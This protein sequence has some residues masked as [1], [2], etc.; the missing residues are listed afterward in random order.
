MHL[1]NSS[2]P[3]HDPSSHYKMMEP[4]HDMLYYPNS[5]TAEMTNQT[6]EGFL[7]SI[8]NDD[9][10]LDMAMNE[11][12]YTMRPL[13][14]N[15]A[16]ANVASNISQGPPLSHPL[17]CGLGSSTGVSVNED[18]MEA[19][20][21]SAVSSM[22]SERIPPMT[23]PPMSDNEWA[24]ADQHAHASHDSSPYSL[25]Y[26]IGKLRGYEYYGKDGSHRVAAPVA[27]KKHQMFGKRFQQEQG[28]VSHPYALSSHP[29]SGLLP[30][31]S[32]SG[33]HQ[34]AGAA[35]LD[36]MEMKYSCSVDFARHHND[37]RV[38]GAGGPGDVIHSN[39][40]YSLPPTH[41]ENSTM[42]QGSRSPRGPPK[43]KSKMMKKFK[44]EEHL[45]RDEK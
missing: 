15:T 23:D 22:G 28:G 27:Q 39:H 7:S 36:P 8:L 18:R 30:Y 1:T 9:D 44:S 41:S 11:G 33:L 29:P 10:L 17:N 4:S 38:G 19:S 14:N 12:L 25:D 40:T 32:S 6:T 37:V 24:D 16:A 26:P 21:D 2:D 45:S 35:S 34:P 31:P 3:M 13:D 20:S 43:E 42:M 5:T